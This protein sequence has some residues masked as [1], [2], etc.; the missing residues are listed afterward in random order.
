MTAEMSPSGFSMTQL[1]AINLAKGL[2]LICLLTLAAV[3][4]IQDQRQVLYLCL[5]GGYCL[6]W[7]FE[8]WLFPT[9]SQQIFTERVN[10][11]TVI[12]ILLFVGLFYALPGYLAFT[13]PTPISYLAMAIALLLYIFGSLINTGA[14]VQKMVAKERGAGLVS[15]GSWRHIRHINYL[16]DLM[17]YTSFSVLAGSGWAFILPGTIAALYVQRIQQ[18]ERSMAAKYPDFAAYQQT[19]RRLIPWLW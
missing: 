16:G 8:Q 17:R 19:S 15:D 10:A 9:R 14:D 12:S 2:T 11:P 1:F 3:Y 7:L 6:W 13:N 5:H 18:K 4:G